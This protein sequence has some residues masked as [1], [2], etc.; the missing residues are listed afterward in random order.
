MTQIAIKTQIHA[1]QKATNEAIKTKA[2]ARKFLMDAGIIKPDKKHVTTSVR[3]NH[4][5]K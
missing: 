5:K 4:Q 1:I 3:V 2:S